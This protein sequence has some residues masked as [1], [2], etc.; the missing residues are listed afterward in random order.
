M[1]P[2]E[3][4]SY[5]VGLILIVAIGTALGILLADAIAT[6]RESRFDDLDDY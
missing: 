3:F 6:E 4:A 2:L 5:A 1:T